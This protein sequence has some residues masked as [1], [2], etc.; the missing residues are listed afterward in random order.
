MPC[1]KHRGCIVSLIGYDTVANKGHYS[2]GERIGLTYAAI[3]L[4]EIG[5]RSAWVGGTTAVPPMKIS[6]LFSRETV[7]SYYYNRKI[8]NRGGAYKNQMGNL[9]PTPRNRDLKFRNGS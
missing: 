7:G 1:S 5:S 9:S 8:F 2:F 3:N 6:G 4:I